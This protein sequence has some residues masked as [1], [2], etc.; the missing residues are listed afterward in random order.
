M[1]NTSTSFIYDLITCSEQCLHFEDGRTIEYVG[2]GFAL[3]RT[4]N[5]WVIYMLSA[6]SSLLP[7]AFPGYKREISD[8]HTLPAVLSVVCSNYEA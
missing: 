1:N 3:K 4:Q 6:S 2:G 5:S 8:L 7:Q